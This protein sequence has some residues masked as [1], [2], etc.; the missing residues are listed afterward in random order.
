MNYCLPLK[1]FFYVIIFQNILIKA[2]NS[3]ISHGI[4][5]KKITNRYALP[6]TASSAVTKAAVLSS[7]FSVG[8]FQPQA[9]CSL[10]NLVD[11]VDFS[12]FANVG[13]SSKLWASFCDTMINENCDVRV[14]N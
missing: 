6:K 13:F 3:T 2:I 9:I 7:P 10:N 14:S 11:S 5:H 1:L 4:F 8:S 12:V